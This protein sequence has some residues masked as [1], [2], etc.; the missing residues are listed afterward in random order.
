MSGS[1]ARLYGIT[2][3]HTHTQGGRCTMVD[4]A[5]NT[6]SKPNPGHTLSKPNPGRGTRHDNGVMCRASCCR[7]C[8]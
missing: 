6:L 4:T 3:H 7:A 2:V 1:T 8:R 5:R